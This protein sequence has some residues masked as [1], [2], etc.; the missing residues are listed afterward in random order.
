MNL[1]QTLE[2]DEIA[3]LGIAFKSVDIDSVAFQK[4]DL[5]TKVR[6]VLKQRTGSPTIPQIWIGGTH[7]GGAMDLF[8]AMRTGR[9][10][11]LLS[12]AGVGYDRNA[13]IDPGDFL[14][15]WLHP[16]KAA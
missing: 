14:P 6:A 5:G 7:V 1:I 2:Q 12:E 11:R 16:R 9:M 4:H 8:D 3:R 10:Q 13:D 15:K